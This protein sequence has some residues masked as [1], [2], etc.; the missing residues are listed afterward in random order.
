[1][2]LPLE[3]TRLLDTISYWA[4]GTHSTYSSKLRVIRAFEDLFGITI[5]KTTRLEHAP[6]SMEIS[7]MW[8]HVLYGLRKSDR[9]HERK[10]EPSSAVGLQHNPTASIGSFSIPY[11]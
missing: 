2:L 3:R 10:E 7:L 9:P 6:E 11:F 8:C 1:M 5:L 4:K